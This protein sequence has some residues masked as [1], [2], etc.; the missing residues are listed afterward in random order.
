MATAIDTGNSAA[1][2]FDSAT[3]LALLA[4]IVVGFRNKDT[5]S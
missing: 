1:P 2:D 3:S 5:A 4:N